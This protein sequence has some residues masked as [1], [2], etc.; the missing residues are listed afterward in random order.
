MLGKVKSSLHSL[1]CLLKLISGLRHRVQH[2]IAP[3]QVL[4]CLHDRMIHKAVCLPAW[5]KAGAGSQGEAAQRGRWEGMR[6][7][8]ECW[9]GMGLSAEK[10]LRL[11]IKQEA[12]CARSIPFVSP[13]LP[14][15]TVS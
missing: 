9:P 6:R 14:M 12:P 7:H 10:A 15:L 2:Q 4:L 5:S 3:C 13:S 11:I 1:H 8:N